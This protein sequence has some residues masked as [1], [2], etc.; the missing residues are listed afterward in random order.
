MIRYIYIY[1]AILSDNEIHFYHIYA[2]FLLILLGILPSQGPV[3]QLKNTS[4]D[5]L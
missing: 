1:A 2:I 5:V 3:L 4:N